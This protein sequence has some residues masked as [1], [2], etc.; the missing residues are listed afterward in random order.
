MATTFKKKRKLFGIQF[1]TFRGKQGD[2][3]LVLTAGDFKYHVY[4]EV[5]A[6]QAARDCG[7]KLDQRHNDTAAMWN[8][9]WEKAI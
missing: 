6:K 3:Y 5:D 7:C 2:D 9:I 4:A 1:K 8:D